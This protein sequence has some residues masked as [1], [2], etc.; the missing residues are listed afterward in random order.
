MYMYNGY[1]E[2]CT[3]SFCVSLDLLSPWIYWPRSASDQYTSPKRFDS[4]ACNPACTTVVCMH[5]SSLQ[6]SLHTLFKSHP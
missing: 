5:S 1:I 4:D 3:I 2:Q 6:F